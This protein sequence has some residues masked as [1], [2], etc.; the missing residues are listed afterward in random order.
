MTTDL[1]SFSAKLRVLA[2]P[3]IP[4]PEA[5]SGVD[6]DVASLFERRLG[7]EAMRALVDPVLAGIY[8]GRPEDLSL[9]ATLPP[10][11]RLVVHAVRRHELPRMR[12]VRSI[13]G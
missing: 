1:L 11:A 12:L 3:F 2:E 10:V 6:T 8:A 5:G 7:S 13:G 4:W 9:R